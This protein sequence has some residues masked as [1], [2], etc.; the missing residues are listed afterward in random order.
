MGAC[1]TAPVS[2][3]LCLRTCQTY[4]SSAPGVRG[5]PPALISPQTLPETPFVL[6]RSLQLELEPK[7]L[8]L[9][10]PTPGTAPPFPAKLIFVVDGM[11]GEGPRR[12][13]ELVN[14]LFFTT[15]SL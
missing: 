7:S 5:R 4:L 12:C 11:E 14:P 9:H 3:S 6:F 1:L 8:S 15:K 13:L 10:G 2:A